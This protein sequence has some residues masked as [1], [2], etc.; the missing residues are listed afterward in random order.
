MVAVTV[1]EWESISGL[2]G[3]DMDSLELLAIESP[4]ILGLA[5]ENHRKVIKARNYVGIIGFSDDNSLEIL[6]KIGCDD[7]KKRSILMD[8][9]SVTH[10][11]FRRTDDRTGMGTKNSILEFYIGMYIGEC[12]HV[13]MKGLNSKYRTY[14][15]NEPFVRGKILHAED[16]KRNSVLR[17]RF[18]VEYELFGNDSPENRIVRMTLEKLLAVS[19]D[20]QNRKRL[21]W[22]LD[23]FGGVRS[24]PDHKAEFQRMTKDRNTTHYSLLLKW[25][26]I[27]LDNL[28]LQPIQGTNI[29]YVFLF[30]MEKLYES[31]VYHKLKARLPKGWSLVF[32]DG[33][34]HLF[35][36]GKINLRPDMV[37]RGDGR[38]IV[39]DTKWKDPN[40][41]IS[42]QDL[43]QM[44]IY[45]VKYRSE[46]TILLYPECKDLDY[47]DAENSVHI[48]S[49]SF[50]IEESSKSAEAILGC[51][52]HVSGTTE[53]R[54]THAQNFGPRA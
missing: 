10:E 34:R 29:A 4:D 6:P 18:Y 39:L 9:L 16:I 47:S 20:N 8:M 19:R 44:Y 51:L 22:L 17:N 45:S 54:Y 33:S 26:R 38:T 13:L 11:G 12:S 35:D 2:S 52:I 27:F 50:N 25:S 41:G 3:P 53:R 21:R 23:R 5:I 14:Q 40:N 49:M 28:G 46:R 30:P 32:Q 15:S 36:S 1:S 24:V 7:E 48:S 43:Y 42:V 31:F 37:L